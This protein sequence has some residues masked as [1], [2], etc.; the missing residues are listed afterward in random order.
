MKRKPAEVVP[1]I[2]KREYE[3]L[4]ETLEVAINGGAYEDEPGMESE[5]RT[6]RAK[7]AR[8]IG[9]VSPLR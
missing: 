8:K 7:L 6:I 2:T 5:Y 1:F 4:W 3:L 9:K